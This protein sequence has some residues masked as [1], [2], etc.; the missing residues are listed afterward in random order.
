MS[1]SAKL[2]AAAGNPESAGT[3]GESESG[4]CAPRMALG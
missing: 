3:N 4:S 2:S 1:T